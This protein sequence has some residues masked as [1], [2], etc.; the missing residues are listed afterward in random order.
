MQHEPSHPAAQHATCDA[1]GVRGAHGTWAVAA[2]SRRQQATNHAHLPRRIARCDRT[3][4][5][6]PAHTRAATGK[7]WAPPNP[8]QCKANAGVSRISPAQAAACHFQRRS[9]AGAQYC[10]RPWDPPRCRAR[11]PPP[12]AVG[13]VRPPTPS[14]ISGRHLR[15]PFSARRVPREQAVEPLASPAAR[16]SQRPRGRRWNSAEAPRLSVAHQPTR[17]RG[18]RAEHRRSD[19]RAAHRGA[20]AQPSPWPALRKG[21]GDSRSPS[22]ARAENSIEGPDDA[23]SLVVGST[24]TAPMRAG[25]SVQSRARPVRA[26]G[27]QRRSCWAGPVSGAMR[28]IPFPTTVYLVA[29]VARG[30]I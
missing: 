26:A 25:R 4:R 17:A 21:D 10:E 30:S 23:P 11:P 18:A 8:P 1:R 19:H 20:N 27:T 22:R 14:T 12:T 3:T 15:W 6:W 9:R 13:H 7:G 24:L 2:D 16:R 28:N 5:L 29:R